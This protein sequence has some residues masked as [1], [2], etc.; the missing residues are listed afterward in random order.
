MDLVP[1]ATAWYGVSVVRRHP[2]LLQRSRRGRPRVWSPPLT[3]VARFPSLSPDSPPLPCVPLFTPVAA[4]CSRPPTAAVPAFLFAAGR[5]GFPRRPS[6][7]TRVGLPLFPRFCAGAFNC[8]FF[9]PLFTRR[10]L[11]RF[12]FAAAL[13]SGPT[14]VVPLGLG[15]APRCL[16]PVLAFRGRSWSPASPYFFVHYPCWL[17]PRSASILQSLQRFS[18]HPVV[19]VRVSVC[20]NRGHNIKC[21]WLPWLARPLPS[22]GPGGF[23]EAFMF[24]LAVRGVASLHS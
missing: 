16:C 11:W 4:F 1:I 3:S 14:L 12:F 5:A 19:R 2:V 18:G 15:R 17:S 13:H 23:S 24:L 7:R 22:R 10:Y 9:F 21:S 20:L 6:L 8:L